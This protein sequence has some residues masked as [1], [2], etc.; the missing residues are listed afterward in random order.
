VPDERLEIEIALRD[1]A[2]AGRFP[3]ITTT[4]GTGTAL[5]DVRLEAVEA[6]CKRMLLGFCESMQ[7]VSLR[8][9]PSAI[10]FR[11]AAD[12][13]GCSLIVNL[14]GTLSAIA[15]CLDAV[16]LAIPYRCVAFRPRAG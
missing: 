11:Q 13:R 15:E 3:L 9:V 16:F 10:L 14:P 2:G 6:V 8:V 5:R 12:T 4:G 7:V 1:L